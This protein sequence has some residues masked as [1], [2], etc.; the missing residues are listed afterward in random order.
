[1]KRYDYRCYGLFAS[2]SSDVWQWTI[3][4]HVMAIFVEINIF[5]ATNILYFL[6]LSHKKYSW[7][8][9]FFP[10]FAFCNPVGCYSIIIGLWYNI[11][12]FAFQ[13]YFTCLKRCF[14]LFHHSQIKHKIPDVLYFWIY[15]PIGLIQYSKKKKTK[16][17]LCKIETHRCIRTIYFEI[18]NVFVR[19]WFPVWLIDIMSL[20]R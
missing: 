8:F 13:V 12:I 16:N 5:I 11:H 19:K 4:C 17:T 15:S 2:L 14:F 9:L 3:K 1:M 10:F 7:I 6:V 18:S 20:L